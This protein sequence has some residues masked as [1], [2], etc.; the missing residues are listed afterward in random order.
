[1]DKEDFNRLMRSMNYRQKGPLLHVISHI[2]NAD[3]EEP[4]K[5]FLTGPAGYGKTFVINLLREIYNRFCHTDGYCDPY[6]TCASMGK[7]A[8][9][10][11]GTTVQTAFKI[12]IGR[13]QPLSFEVAQQLR[14]L[15]KYIE[16]ILIDKVSMIS[17]ELNGKIDLRLRQITA[18][19][20]SYGRKDIFFIGDLRRQLP[21]VRATPIYN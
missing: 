6:V 13:L 5:I 18:T 3:T 8:V 7:A 16:C 1:M 17:A 12:T 15:F 14:S 20:S 2:L 4:L 21:A 10:I 9:A 11:E 19:N